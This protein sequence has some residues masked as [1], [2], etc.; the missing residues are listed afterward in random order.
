VAEELTYVMLKP[1]KVGKG[2]RHP[3]ELVPE[4]EQWASRNAYISRGVIAPVPV[5]GLSDEHKTA[6]QAWKTNQEHRSGSRSPRPESEVSSTPS[7]ASGSGLA[8]HVD[9]MTIS[10]IRQKVIDGDW[11][12]AEVWEAESEGKQRS[13]LLDWLEEQVEDEG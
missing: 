7:G 2:T 3:G 5:A 9:D 8:D 13:T 1:R 11:D 12:P 10:E 6:Y 4:A